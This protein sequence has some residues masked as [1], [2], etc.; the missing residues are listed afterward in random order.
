MPYWRLSSFY[1]F[2]F[3]ALGVLIPFWGL[4]LRDRGFSPLA[5][6]ELIAIL[7]AT[8]ILAPILWGWIA[9][10]VGVRLPIVRLASLLSLLAFSGIFVVH[11]FWGIALV[12][13]LFSS[14]WHAS[15]PQIEAATF[16]HLGPR[17]HRY[18]T[19]RL[20]GSISFILV[21][22]GLGTWIGRTGTH[23]VPQLILLCF[24]GIW[25][26]SLTIPDPWQ[27]STESVSES[28]V[29]RLKT[30]EIAA[31]LTACFLMQVSHGASYTFYSIYLME[32]GYSGTSIGMLWAWGVIMEVLVFWRMHRL[33]EY[34]G[35]R[36]VLLISLG[37]AVV[38]WLLTGGFVDYPWLQLC[39]QTLH[40][41]TFGAFHATAIHLVH[42][43]FSGRTQGR[44][45]ALYGSLSFG[46][47]VTVGSLLSGMLWSEAGGSFV[48]TLSALAAGLGW[49]VVWRWVDKEH[50]F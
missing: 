19:V 41:A 3:A 42:H 43:Y 23:I 35:A 8:K 16:D 50:R 30:P 38:R 39:A 12:T 47:G 31:F 9:D 27:S 18:A 10:H 28:L 45:Q 2:Y 21:V 26:S 13:T 25:L 33:L 4:Y 49:L 37:L 11:G 20:W 14:F 44:G 17:L 7:M 24:A 29:S 5:V 32:A 46:A 40:A 36:R 15:L 1:F 34:F 48:F 6:G 22:L